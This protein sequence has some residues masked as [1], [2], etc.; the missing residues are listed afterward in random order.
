[1]FRLKICGVLLRWTYITSK[2]VGRTCLSMLFLLPKETLLWTSKEVW[3]EGGTF[4][5]P[6]VYCKSVYCS[7]SLVSFWFQT[8]RGMYVKQKRTGVEA[9]TKW[10]YHLYPLSVIP[11][12]FCFCFIH[13]TELRPLLINSL[14]LIIVLSK[15]L[16]S[17]Q[18]KNG[19]ENNEP[20][21]S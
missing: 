3:L 21:H 19:S 7:F 9:V 4:P 8:Q 18:Q 15:N 17:L 14:F 1:M 12:V 11:G 20:V 13:Q 5:T 16:T 2:G 10:K 6:R